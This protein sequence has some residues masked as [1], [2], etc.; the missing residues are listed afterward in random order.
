MTEKIQKSLSKEFQK[1]L[2]R[3]ASANGAGWL[4]PLREEA[5][6]RFER[7]GIPTVRQEPWRFTNLSSLAKQELHVADESTEFDL[8]KEKI[9]FLSIPG[10]EKRR[11]VFVNGYFSEQHSTTATLPAGAALKNLNEAIR[12]D[13]ERLEPLL[14]AA[15][16]RHEDTFG[17]LN[18]AM[19]QDGLFLSLPDETILDQPVYLMF[20][21]VPGEKNAAVFPRNVILAGKGAKAEIVEQYVSANENTAMTAG[22]TEVFCDEMS[23]VSHYR[24]NDENHHSYN[25]STLRTRLKKDSLFS[26]HTLLLGGALNRNNIFP[27][28]EGTG[29]LCLLNGLFMG[30]GKQHLDSYITIDHLAENCNSRQFYKGILDEESRGV[31]HGRIHVHKQAQKTDAIQ[32]NRNLLLSRTAQI[33]TKPQLE[34]YADDVRCTHGATVGQIDEGAVFYLRSRG[35]EE[36]QARAML[37]GAFAGEALER[38]RPGPIR[39]FFGLLSDRWFERRESMEVIS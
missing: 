10:L 17:A 36:K 26:S 39:D 4:R 21:T 18:D 3:E 38:M 37:V 19:M 12:T 32:N 14:N 27:M 25:L 13:R 28:I 29:A 16:K 22:V 15:N 24:I 20:V 34:I 33:D 6:E 7:M 1:F 11:L 30:R 9:E 35:I 31:F 2:S 8:R 23:D 5:F